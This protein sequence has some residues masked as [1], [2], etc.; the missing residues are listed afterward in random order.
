M[1][2][3]KTVEINR[4]Q[5]YNKQAQPSEQNIR[6]WRSWIAQ[7][8]PILKI[9]GSNPSGRAKGKPLAERQGAFL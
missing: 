5:W 2:R 9:G 3:Q 1:R 6:P 4:M 7:Q 8:I